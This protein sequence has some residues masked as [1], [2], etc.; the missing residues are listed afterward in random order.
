MK[1]YS[2]EITHR[3]AINRFGKIGFVL[4]IE[5]FKANNEKNVAEANR[6]KRIKFEETTNAEIVRLLR[7]GEKNKIYN[8]KKGEL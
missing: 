2:R 1:Y 3:E 4:Y 8:F 6:G 7:K 5:A